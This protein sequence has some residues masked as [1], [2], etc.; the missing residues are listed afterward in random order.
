MLIKIRHGLNKVG[1][2]NIYRQR[3]KKNRYGIS[4]GFK[5]KV[6]FFGIT[7]IPML[8]S[9]GLHTGKKSLYAFLPFWSMKSIMDYVGYVKVS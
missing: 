6:N 7:K 8:S 5:R 4:I 2:S 1:I 3:E 9:V